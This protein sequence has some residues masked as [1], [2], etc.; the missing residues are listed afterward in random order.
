MLTGSV[1]GDG[2]YA[3]LAE[4]FAASGGALA[5]YGTLFGVREVHRDE[6]S[7]QVLGPGEHD[8]IVFERRPRD[9]T[10]GGVHHFGFR[11]VSPDAIA[12]FMGPEAPLKRVPPIV[13]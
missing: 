7:I 9:A 1:V 5:F 3:T 12:T 10:R 13:R 6:R 4:L 11:L 8:V 2:E